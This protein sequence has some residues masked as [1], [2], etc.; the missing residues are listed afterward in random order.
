MVPI[1]LSN[2][3]RD[4]ILS[5]NRIKF[6]ECLTVDDQAKGARGAVLGKS[7][8]VTIPIDI[9]ATECGQF[10]FLHIILLRYNYVSSMYHQDC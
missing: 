5:S 4:R 7:R 8:Y 1:D 3:A 9:M 6:V 10:P 2:I